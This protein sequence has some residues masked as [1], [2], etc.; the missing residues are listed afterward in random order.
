M[1]LL[2]LHELS[3]AYGAVDALKGLTLKVGEGEIVALLGSNG[4]GK[5]TTLRTIS[6]LMKPRAGRVLFDGR[7][8]SGVHPEKVARLGVSHVPE[9]RRVFP[10][11]TVKENIMLGASN[12]RGI[13]RRALEA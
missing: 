4:A 6:G 11:L 1:P 12:R 3:A 7:D 10:G 13:A 2:E 5:S 9:A 8:I